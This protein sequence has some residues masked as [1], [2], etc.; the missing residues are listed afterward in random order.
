[1]P[2]PTTFKLPRLVEILFDVISEL[3]LLM[4]QVWS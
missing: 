4:A 1:M 2:T 3:I